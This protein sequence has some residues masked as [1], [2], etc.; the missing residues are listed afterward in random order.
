MTR[1][2]S[3]PATRRLVALSRFPVAPPR[4]RLARRALEGAVWA[5]AWT[6]VWGCALLMFAHRAQAAPLAVSPGPA[7]LPICED[8]ACGQIPDE[9]AACVDVSA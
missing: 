7:S 5:F 8:Q 3:T 9:A 1:P 2:A 4:A 6:L